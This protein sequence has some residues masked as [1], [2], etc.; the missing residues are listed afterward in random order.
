MSNP[1]SDK[2]PSKDAKVVTVTAFDHLKEQHEE[3]PQVR[4]QARRGPLVF[5]R[6]TTHP[7]PT[8]PRQFQPLPG[9]NPL[10]CFLNGAIAGVSGGILGG[11]FG[12]GEEKRRLC[13]P[14]CPVWFS[15][16]VTLARPVQCKG[17]SSRPPQRWAA[18]RAP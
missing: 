7:L 5:S 14:S 16:R 15:A 13:P 4:T 11:V 17:P 9:D 12:L 18:S 6:N 8:S 1:A 2:G 10:P 3:P